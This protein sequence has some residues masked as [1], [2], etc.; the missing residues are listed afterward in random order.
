MGFPGMGMPGMGMPGMGMGMPGMLGMN[1]MR[2][3]MMPGMSSMMHMQHGMMG[4]PGGYFPPS[5]YGASMMHPAMMHPGNLHPNFIQPGMINPLVLGMMGGGSGGVM[6]HGGG[7]SCMCNKKPCEPQAQPCQQP[8]EVDP[9]RDAPG[10]G[11]SH[12]SGST[13]GLLGFGSTGLAEG[14]RS[15]YFAG[16]GC[17][18]NPSYRDSHGYNCW[19]WEGYDC[20]GSTMF[21]GYGPQEYVQMRMLCPKTCGLC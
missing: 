21:Q 5:G 20:S 4:M 14:Y 8:C 12:C 3:G 13:C 19:G 1:M 15:G 7:Q 17:S 2:M 18:D 11:Q 9:P 6:T 10:C 16:R